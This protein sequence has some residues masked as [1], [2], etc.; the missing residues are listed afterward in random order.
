MAAVD[1]NESSDNRYEIMAW[2]GLDVWLIAL[3]FAHLFETKV[4]IWNMLGSSGT[5]FICGFN[6]QIFLIGF[7]INN[8]YIKWSTEHCQRAM[9]SQASIHPIPRLW[10]RQREAIIGWGNEAFM[11]CYQCTG[12]M[13]TVWL[14]C[15]VWRCKKLVLEAYK[16]SGRLATW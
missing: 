7:V 5:D 16:V 10:T 11:N 2:F 14:Y 1:A 9:K 8:Q 15:D 13:I 6:C 3:G 4:N 12:C